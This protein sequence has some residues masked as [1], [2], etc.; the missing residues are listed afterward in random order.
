VA[1]DVRGGY[2]S[3][4]S[5]RRDYGVV[6]NGSGVD[7]RATAE[8][9]KRLASE[10]PAL[11]IVADEADPYEGIKGRHRVLR[12]HPA[13]A[14]KLQVRLNDLVEL[15]GRHPSP[16]RAWIGISDSAPRDAAPL[17]AFGRSVLGVE[18]GGRV[19]LRK[20]DAPIAPGQRNFP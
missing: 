1:E 9:R 18:A 5:A 13:L 3:A 12:L 4:E 6:L 2:V 20:L 11:A 10:F 19:R 15:I 17:D 7:Q 16:L 14:A 8:C